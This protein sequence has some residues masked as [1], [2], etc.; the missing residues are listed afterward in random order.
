MSAHIDGFLHALERSGLAMHK[1]GVTADGCLHRYRVEGDKA[2]STNGWYVLHLDEKPFGAFGSWKTG[3]SE[4]WA[5]GT[6][7]TMSAA[8]RQAMAERMA[9]AKR[10]RDAEQAAVQ[11]S[12]RK[13]ALDLWEKA[14]PADSGH[15][16]LARKAV[17]AYGIKLLREQLVVPLRDV[18]GVLHSLQ[19]IGSDGRKT[20]LTG[21]RKRGC[22]HAIGKPAGALCIC[23]GY[24]TG[25]TIYQ[26]TGK[27]T[28][29]AF[30]ANNLQPVA[31]ALRRKFPRLILVIA[32]DNDTETPGNPGLTAAKEAARAVGAVVVH[33]QFEGSA[34]V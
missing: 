21:G 24:A 19:F 9:A 28:A 29:V 11:T 2:G 13:R 1:P 15:A 32:A 5:P 34:H 33:P 26:A 16:Y 31:R 27:A 8:E 18:D 30:D 12:A 10:A 3:Q 20:F 22:Y 14:K 4:T 25:A 6:A 17:P 23:E 7:E